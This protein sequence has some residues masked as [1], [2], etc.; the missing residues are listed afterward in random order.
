VTLT[1]NTNAG[2]PTNALASVQVTPG[3]NTRVYGGLY[4]QQVPFTF[5]LQPGTASATLY[6][7]RLTAGQASNASVVVTDGCG[8][9]PTFVGGGP[10]AF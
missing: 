8:A 3:A 7:E 6:L 1:A 5:T 9:W 10:S 2:T 4:A